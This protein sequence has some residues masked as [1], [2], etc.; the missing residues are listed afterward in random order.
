MPTP[1]ATDDDATIASA[2]TPR[3]RLRVGEPLPAVMVLRDFESLLG[4]G[5][6]SVWDLYKGGQLARFELDKVGGRPRF[7]GQAVQAWLDRAPAE[8]L[9]PRRFLNSARRLRTAKAGR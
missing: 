4:I 3:V 1:P 9:E 6:T 8:E 7:S 5:P 2:P